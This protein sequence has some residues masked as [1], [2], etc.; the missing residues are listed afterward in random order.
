MKFDQLLEKK[1]FLTFQKISIKGDVKLNPSRIANSK[2]GTPLDSKVERYR[3]CA[4]TKSGLLFRAKMENE[5]M[6]C[7]IAR[8]N[9]CAK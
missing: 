6:T 5:M 7:A 9:P 8:E 1:P 4:C 2:E 3:L